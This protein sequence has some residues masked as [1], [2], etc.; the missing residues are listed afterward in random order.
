MKKIDCYKVVVVTYDVEDVANW[1][2]VTFS[3]KR[4]AMSYYKSVLAYWSP[5]DGSLYNDN[6][7]IV[8]ISFVIEYDDHTLKVPFSEYL[9]F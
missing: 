2:T 4:K 6:V 9:R 5:I 7:R 8:D 1:H 3:D